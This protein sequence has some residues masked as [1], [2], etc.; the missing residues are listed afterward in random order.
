MQKSLLSL[1]KI[2]Q[3]VL[4]ALCIRSRIMPTVCQLVTRTIWASRDLR[5]LVWPGL[6]EVLSAHYSCVTVLCVSSLWCHDLIYGLWL[7]HASHLFCALN[8]SAYKCH[9]RIT[10][11]NSL[12]PYQARQNVGPD[13]E[14]NRLKLLW[15]SWNLSLES[16]SYKNQ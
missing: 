16:L 9:L 13:L 3:R 6:T 12:D 7:C 11:E 5:Y 8:N 10:F 2:W 15:H 14:P 1:Y 4:V